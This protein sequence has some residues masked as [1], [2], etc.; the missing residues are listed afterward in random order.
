MSYLPGLHNALHRRLHL[1]LGVYSDCRDLRCDRVDCGGRRVVPPEQA[2]CVSSVS[3]V[4]KNLVWPI[5]LALASVKDDYVLFLG[6]PN[7]GSMGQI[8][9]GGSRLGRVVLLNRGAVQQNEDKIL[10]QLEILETHNSRGASVPAG[11]V[12][13]NNCHRSTNGA[14]C[15]TIT[16]LQKDPIEPETPPRTPYDPLDPDQ[17]QSPLPLPPDSNPQPGAPVTEPDPPTPIV[18]P[19][20]TEPTRLSH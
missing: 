12:T 13:A 2:V 7:T 8:C 5:S 10:F 18:D 3:V 17:P 9:S 19:T 16:V 20:P 14:K 1:S 4:R 6:W 15:M 11:G